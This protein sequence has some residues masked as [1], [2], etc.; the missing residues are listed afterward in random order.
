MSFNDKSIILLIIFYNIFYYCIEVEEKKEIFTLNNSTEIN[1]L[2]SNEIIHFEVN[3]DEIIID[4]IV[5]TGDAYIIYNETYDILNFELYDL[6]NNQRLIINNLYNT[7]FNFSIKSNKD[8]AIYKLLFRNKDDNYQKIWP[9]KICGIETFDNELDDKDILFSLDKN[10]YNN[11]EERIGIFFNLIN[12]DYD[13]NFINIIRNIKE[14]LTYEFEDLDEIN[15]NDNCLLYTGAVNLDLNTSFLT[16]PQGNSLKFKLNNDIKIIRTNFYH[17]YSSVDS[18]VYLR[19]VLFND[20]PI[21]LKIKIIKEKNIILQNTSYVISRTQNILVLSKN[22]SNDLNL[23]KDTLYEIRMEFIKIKEEEEEAIFDIN[24][25]TLNIF[26][27]LIKPKEVTTDV[28]I[29]NEDNI[30]YYFTHIS[31]KSLGYIKLIF[32]RGKGHMFAKLINLKKLKE[33]GGWKDKI[34]LP[35]ENGENQLN[36][37]YYEQLITFDKKHTNQCGQYC[38]LVFGIQNVKDVSE[39]NYLNIHFELFSEYTIIYRSFEEL[40]NV[41][42]NYL[43]LQNNQFIY[44][45]LAYANR[46]ENYK[47]YINNKNEDILY[48]EFKSDNCALD[49]KFN[50][51]IVNITKESNGNTILFNL[52]KNNIK[53]CFFIKIRKIQED[54]KSKDGNMLYQLKIVE[55][56]NLFKEIIKIESQHS[57]ICN[58]TYK[59]ITDKNYCDYLLNLDN[60]YTNNIIVELMANEINY[61]T[62]NLSVYINIID[63]DAFNQNLLNNTLPKWPNKDKH[64]HLLLD[65]NKIPNN[66][67]NISLSNYYKSQ[68]IDKI[69]DI[70]SFILLIRVYYEANSIIELHTIIHKKLTNNT[71]GVKPFHNEYQFLSCYINN[72]LKLIIPDDELYYVQFV[73]IDGKARISMNDRYIEIENGLILNNITNKTIF[74]ENLKERILNKSL[75]DLEYDFPYYRFFLFFK[76]NL[77]DNYQNT[78]NNLEKLKNS[79]GYKFYNEKDFPISYLIDI[80]YAD[81]KTDLFYYIYFSKLI[82]GKIIKEDYKK[83]FTGSFDLTAELINQNYLNEQNKENNPEFLGKYDVAYHGGRIIIPYLNISEY[84]RF[85]SKVSI[86]IKIN[87]MKSHYNNRIYL[88]SEGYL[89]VIQQNK[90]MKNIPK[91]YYI[92]NYFESEPNNTNYSNRTHIYKLDGYSNMDI[93]KEIHIHFSSNSKDISYFFSKNSSL[94]YENRIQYFSVVN[95]NETGNEDIF[96]PSKGPEEIYL[97]VICQPNNYD[98]EYSFNYLAVDK[99][100]NYELIYFNNEINYIKEKEY[101]SFLSLNINKIVISDNFSINYYVRIYE[102][103]LDSIDDLNITSSF[104]KQSPYLIYKIEND[105]DLLNISENY[106][107]LNVSADVFKKYFIDAIAEIIIDEERQLFDYLGYYKFY[108]KAVLKIKDEETNKSFIIVLILITFFLLIAISILINYTCRYRNKHKNLENKIKQISMIGGDKT[109]EEDEEF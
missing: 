13:I 75:E 108:P 67:I 54:M 42:I 58:K 98:I 89:F 74:I 21:I 59:N 56:N 82:T 15:E 27:Y 44:N 52:N 33:K 35:E 77:K 38:Y 81:I 109:D 40:T 102:D 71:I 72:K 3:K 36:F 9:L 57:V 10:D 5:L 55:V 34:I 7:I 14:N 103:K 1:Y 87:I 8:G 85:H 104:R 78:E 47:Y 50:K 37:D 20:V 24:I 45:S 29:N 97:I 32:K 49:I 90:I 61:I 25:K 64:Y 4:L 48:V 93:N 101:S 11:E 39:N 65:N 96:V 86:F 17:A 83:N 80:T 16:L 28:I 100:N 51:K 31:W 66:Y 12:C 53:E 26:P 63:S 95:I 92:S 22:D 105:V 107:I 43:N 84:K 79:N 106:F 99:K 41:N 23:Q 60:I 2:P 19:I 94:E 70:S 62:T 88:N 76:R 69:K 30:N 46:D 6:G 91:N 18:E 68:N 73:S